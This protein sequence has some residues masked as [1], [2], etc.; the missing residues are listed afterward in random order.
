MK[1]RKQLKRFTGLFILVLVCMFSMNVNAQQVT[2]SGHVK[3]SKGEVLPGATA[4]EKGTMNGTVTNIDGNYSI[5]LGQSGTLV[6]SFIGM[7]TQ[8][9]GVNRQTTIN[10]VM[11]DE[12]FGLEQVVVTGYQSQKKADLTGAIEVV[13]MESIENV[14]LT[15]GNQFTE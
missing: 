10:V 11:V 12:T 5:T 8:E 3:D 15:S 6:F 4:V 1:R 14:S 9:I 2:V 7:S 13:E